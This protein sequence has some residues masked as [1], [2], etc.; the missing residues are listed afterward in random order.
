[1]V[2]MVAFVSGPAVLSA[3]AGA[4]LG[5]GAYTFVYAQGYSYFS[6]NPVACANCHVMR[7]YFDSWQRS[8]HHGCAVC[9][10]C[11]TPHALLPKYLTKAENGWNHSLRFTLQDYSDPIRIRLVNAD[12]LR[13]N[14]L[15][16]HG[17]MAGQMPRQ[18]C[19][20]CHAGVGHG[21]WR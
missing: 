18:D 8:S 10:D 19:V 4:A 17:D 21:P 3:L 9:N 7:G 2:R 16:C 6:N 15:R 11:H 14:C 5:L 1:M 12:K 13:G 20:R